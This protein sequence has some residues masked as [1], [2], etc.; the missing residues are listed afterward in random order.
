MYTKQF[1]II[2]LILFDNFPD[3]KTSKVLWEMSL[4]VVKKLAYSNMVRCFYKPR[5][6]FFF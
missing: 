3:I 5:L 1:H 2:S 4:L 6:S